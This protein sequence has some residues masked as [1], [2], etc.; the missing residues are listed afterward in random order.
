MLDS[1]LLY[2]HQLGALRLPGSEQRPASAIALQVE[3]LS[4]NECTLRHI[5]VSSLSAVNNGS[6]Q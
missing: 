2:I 4:K 6:F 3:S 1:V 5:L